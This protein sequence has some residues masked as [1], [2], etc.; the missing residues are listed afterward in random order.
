MLLHRANVYRLEP[1]AEQANALA[2]WAGACR[3]IYNLAL[4]QRRIFGRDHGINYYLQQAEI[5]A[6]RAEVDW[7]RAVPVHA[8]QMAVRA[9]D[10]AFQNF[11]RAR[12]LSA[13]TQE[14]QERQL[15]AP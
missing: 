7:L 15:H 5:T 11:S 14:V 12:R 1:T 3:F 2:Q 8:L 4:E 10:T 9:V 13:T 6:L